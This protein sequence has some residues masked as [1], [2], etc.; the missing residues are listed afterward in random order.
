MKESRIIKNTFFLYSRTFIMMLL[1]F[2]SGRVTLDML[3]A[4]GY[5][6]YQAVGGCIA[7][8]NTINVGVSAAISRFIA[9]ELGKED[10]GDIS[11][12][13]V[14]SVNVLAVMGIII[15]LVAETIGLWFVHTHMQ[16]P[17]DSIG[18][19]DLI[20]QLALVSYLTGFITLP[21]MSILVAYEEFKY[22]ATLG[23]IQGVMLFC[24]I[25]GI[26]YLPDNR[27]EWFV[28]LSF[29][30]Y[31]LYQFAYSYICIKKHPNIRF[32][33]CF[34]KQKIKEVFSFA[35]FSYIGNSAG[36]LREQG[37]TILINT[38]FGVIYNAARGVSMSVLGAVSV[39]VSNF[40]T[41]LSPQITKSYASED[42]T[43]MWNLVSKGIRFSYFLL[44][45]LS[46]PTIMSTEWMLSSWLKEVP[47]MA[48]TFTRLVI[49]TAL[50]D[51]LSAP[52][53]YLINATGKIALY[54]CVVGGVLLLTI[55]IDLLFLY[56]GF[57]A[58][59]LLWV[60]ICISVV[61][62]F[63]RLLLIK[64]VIIYSISDFLSMVLPRIFIVTLAV[65][66]LCLLFTNYLF[67]FDD[68]FWMGITKF[69]I[70]FILTCSGIVFWGITN[71]ERQTMYNKIRRIVVR[72]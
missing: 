21:F 6:T 45:V 31:V 50:C 22:I 24:F 63:L 5:G 14:T 35:S 51:T 19:V 38:F 72:Y 4:S 34:D 39:L 23:V 58:E 70:N 25:M 11:S 13:F 44:L 69:I 15:A 16:F 62:F 3:G 18:C 52:L 10:K 68:S 17:S 65:I 46:V 71:E 54:Q 9:F 36:V 30:A 33:L 27:L 12:V 53:I 8:L 1:G 2:Y 42:Y 59:V 40:T 48:V 66:V 32:R 28:W 61:S 29:T 20:F 47:P 26:S 41:A 60:N 57:D 67:T 49:I 64:R 56:A 43:F 37:V 7:V 55:P